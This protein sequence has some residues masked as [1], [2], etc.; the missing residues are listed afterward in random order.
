MNRDVNVNNRLRVLITEGSS[1]SAKETIYCLADRCDIE[2]LDPNRLCQCRFSK[3]V[4]TVHRCPNFSRSPEEYLRFLID[5][6]RRQK[7]DVVFPAHEQVYLLSRVR[8]PLGREVGVALPDFDSLHKMQSKSEFVRTLTSLGIPV[9]ETEIVNDVRKLNQFTKYPC[10]VKLAHSTAGTGVAYVRDGKELNEQI[11]RF[12]DRG[13]LDEQ[14]EVLV[15]QPAAGTMSAVQAVFQNGRL[16]AAHCA[17]SLGS[18]VGGGQGCRVSV[19]HPSVIG[20]L[21]TLG[22]HLQW[23]GAMFLEYFFDPNT[24]EPQFIECNPR[25]GETFNAKLSG[26]NLCDLVVRISLG[27]KLEPIKQPGKVGVCSHSDF[28]MLLQQAMQGANRREIFR[29]ALAMVTGRGRY[30]GSTAEITRPSEDWQ[31]LI[32]AVATIA[33]L[34]IRPASARGIVEKAVRSYSLPQS[35]VETIDA[36]TDHQLA[37]NF[38][39]PSSSPG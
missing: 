15:Q 13:W 4:R 16:I 24:E 18:G 7:Y 36:L 26:I 29:E 32:P 9:P 5:R 37:K 3:Y 6:V 34:L 11:A 30:H 14:G 17:V 28:Y 8:E 33:Q 12:R 21:R 19:S 27:E 10:Y 2:L 25:I 20:Y 22:E 31:S 39:L 38:A 23:H 35:G 1:G